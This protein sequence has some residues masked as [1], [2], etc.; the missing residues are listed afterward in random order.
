LPFIGI[1]E[2]FDHKAEDVRC[3][4]NESYH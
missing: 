4:Y 2:Q 1:Y 3:F